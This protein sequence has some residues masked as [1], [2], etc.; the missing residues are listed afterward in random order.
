MNMG[1]LFE[2]PRKPDSP[3]AKPSTF[4]PG[5]MPVF[6]FRAGCRPVSLSRGRGTL[7]PQAD[8]KKAVNAQDTGYHRSSNQVAKSVWA[9]VQPKDWWP[10]RAVERLRVF[11]EQGLQESPVEDDLPE[12]RD[13][14]TSRRAGRHWTAHGIV[15]TA[16]KQ[17]QTSPAR[18]SRGIVLP[19]LGV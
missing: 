1:D 6:V 9:P 8:E 5:M 7:Q 14:C 16:K 11:L 13:I 17:R 10:P 2:Q 12:Q 19:F 3:T 4:S 18:S 15:R